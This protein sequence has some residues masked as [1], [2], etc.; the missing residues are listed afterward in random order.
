MSATLRILA[1][2]SATV[3]YLIRAGQRMRV[4]SPTRAVPSATG[5]RAVN[6]RQFLRLLAWGAGAA[7]ALVI[8]V[9]AGRTELGA[10]RAHAALTAMLSEQATAEPPIS[11]RLTAWSNVVE[12]EM[13]RQAETIRAVT[14]QRDDLAEKVG[15][16]ERQ[17]GDLGDTLARTTARLELETKAAQQAAAMAASVARAGQRPEAPEAAAPAAPASVPA[18]ATAR[19]LASR[20]AVRPLGG[21]SL[22]NLPPPGQIRPAPVAPSS[23]PGFPTAPAEVAAPGPAYTGTVAMSALPESV[24]IMR[25]FSSAP[26][27]A[28]PAAATAAEPSVPL[29]R[30]FPSKAQSLATAAPAVARAPLPTNPP[31]TSGALESPADP[32]ATAA[33]FAVDL[34]AAATVDAARAR[35]N[36]LR[37]SQSPLFDN[38]KPVIAL[39]DGGR[40]GQEL[41]LLAGPLASNAT[42][43]RLCAVLAGTGTPCQSSAFEGQRLNPR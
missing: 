19:T 33:E 34:G 23:G 12:A 11:E 39:K 41:H 5:E 16:I 9:A 30:P 6:A 31:M 40:S 26:L 35:W 25:P 3:A 20:E 28:P 4:G 29:P 27:S 32:G 2:S 10:K 1:P 21:L 14:N 38:L 37:A 8:A 43:A 18:A 15:G 13:R 36:E 24:T 7:L 22:P 17:I 42:S